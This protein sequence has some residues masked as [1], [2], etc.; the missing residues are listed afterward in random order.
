MEGPLMA[1]VITDACVDVK[2]R[3]CVLCC[4][5]DCI[6]EGLRTLYIQPDECINC[7]L[8]V[9]VCPVD[10]IF[11][12]DDV[13]GAQHAFI[14]INR[15]FFSSAVSGLGAPGGAEGRALP[16]DHPHVAALALRSAP[17]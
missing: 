11:E 13:P 8:C 12:Q 17:A 6:Y 1:Y 10:A 15:E 14:A 4:P 16:L 7:A 2:D 3:A 5:V 9:S